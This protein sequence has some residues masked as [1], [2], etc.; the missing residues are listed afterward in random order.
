MLPTNLHTTEP[1][2]GP[3][4]RRGRLRAASGPVSLFLRDLGRALATPSGDAR[5]HVRPY[6][7]DLLRERE[8]I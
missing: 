7:P 5:G 3:G 2:E 6:C 8:Q 4:D 1:D